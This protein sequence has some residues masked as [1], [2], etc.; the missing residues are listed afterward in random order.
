M[1]SHY[2]T[3][4]GHAW[5]LLL[6]TGLYYDPGPHLWIL[7]ATY[8]LNWHSNFE[9]IN[10]SFSPCCF[11]FLFLDESVAYSSEHIW[12]PF[13][14]KCFLNGLIVVDFLMSLMHLTIL[15][16]WRSPSVEQITQGCF[17]PSLVEIDLVVLKKM[18]LWKVFDH[19]D[20]DAS[21]KLWYS[22][23]HSIVT[24]SFVISSDIGLKTQNVIPK[25]V[26]KCC[27]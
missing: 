13:A 11:Y 2:L 15:L 27:R 18:K 20:T 6:W 7:C 19:N 1:H 4:K 12:N 5:S 17:V 8:D 9:L 16:L 24:I 23:M 25:R 22:K 14:P 10:V 21:I 26:S 3:I